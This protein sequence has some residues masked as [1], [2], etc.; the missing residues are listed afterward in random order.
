M[1]HEFKLR[2]RYDGW[3][4]TCGRYFDSEEEL[5]DHIIEKIEED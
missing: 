5:Q 4:C 3:V 1:I 2:T